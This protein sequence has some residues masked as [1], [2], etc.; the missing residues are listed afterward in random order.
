MEYNDSPDRRAYP[1]VVALICISLTL[2]ALLVV[3]IG[4]RSDEIVLQNGIDN[5][6]TK[7]L[8]GTWQF[9]D[10]RVSN[11]KL[12]P[13]VFHPSG[14][15]EHGTTHQI[16]WICSDGIIYL[17]TLRS[18]GSRG[19]EKQQMFPVVPTFDESAGT[20]ELAFPGQPPHAVLSR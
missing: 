13:V 3:A 10:L 8:E 19:D 9:R 14:V 18:E 5:E 15:Y 4:F 2:M 12:A 17:T 20:V 6:L 11:S 7:K 1:L 16:K